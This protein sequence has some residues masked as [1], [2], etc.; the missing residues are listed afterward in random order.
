M[1]R[2]QWVAR[3]ARR[4]V[5]VG[6]VMYRPALRAQTARSHARV[7]ALV[8]HA[9]FAACA[10]R[11]HHTLRATPG[12][13]IAEVFR[14]ACAGRCPMTLATDSVGTAWEV[15]TRVGGLGRLIAN[16]RGQ[17]GEQN[18]TC[19]SFRDHNQKYRQRST[20]NGTIA[21]QT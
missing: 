5:A 1:A 13:W 6:H 3:V 12:V 7:L 21:T 11:V 10:V 19:R 17:D 4:A 16:C 9:R 15:L 8:V 2:C 14:Q 18:A 20:C